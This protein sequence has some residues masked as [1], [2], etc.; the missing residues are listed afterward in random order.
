MSSFW[1]SLSGDLWSSQGLS[2]APALLFRGSKVPSEHP[3]A[4]LFHHLL[5][6][7]FGDPVF[8][9]ILGRQSEPKWLIFEGGEGGEVPEV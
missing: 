9:S 7:W 4:P 2:G 6:H 8:A 5:G 1:G 3:L